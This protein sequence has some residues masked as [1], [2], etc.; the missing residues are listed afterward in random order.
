MRLQVQELCKSYRASCYLIFILA[1]RGKILARDFILFS[2]FG[3]GRAAS[4]CSFYQLG[5]C[6]V[7]NETELTVYF[8]SSWQG[9]F[10]ATDDNVT[11]CAVNH[12]RCLHWSWSQRRYSGNALRYHQRFPRRNLRSGARLALTDGYPLHHR[13]CHIRC[14]NTGTNLARSLRHLGIS[15]LLLLDCWS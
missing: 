1:Q 14:T 7:W 2:F 10:I 12:F 13:R 4:V 5:Q 3:N 11:I 15:G 9:L 8:N 6:T